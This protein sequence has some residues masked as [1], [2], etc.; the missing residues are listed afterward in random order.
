MQF[1]MNISLFCCLHEYSVSLDELAIKLKE[2]FHTE[3]YIGVLELVLQLYQEHLIVNSL[4][5]NKHTWC[6]CESPVYILNGSYPR[7]LMTSLGKLNMEWRRLECTCCKANIV[8][9][10]SALGI[11]KHQYKSNELEKLIVDAAAKDSY[12][13]AVQSI[14]SIGLVSVSSSTAWRWVIQ[15]DCDEIDSSG[16]INNADTPI[17]VFADG[18]KF[19]GLPESGK[20]AKGD[21]K[22]V[23]GV[24]SQGDVFPIGAWSGESWADVRCSIDQKI[25]CFPNDSILVAD[26][27]LGITRAFEDIIDEQQRCH[28]HINRD[29]YHA[30]WQN[31]GTVK[32]SKPVQ[33]ALRALLAIE[34]P[35]GDF[36]K[37]SEQEKDDIEEQMELTESMMSKLI[38]HLESK[39]FTVAAN[40]LFNAKRSMFGYIRRWLKLG[41]ICP[42]AS[43]LI[44]RVMRVL[45]RRIKKIAYNWSDKGVGK[46]ARII[47]KKFMDKKQWDQFWHDKLRLDGSVVFAISNI[48]LAD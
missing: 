5:K 48:K 43:S 9:L 12:R 13:S 24:D 42:R 2:L 7:K 45:A 31:G 15:S 35:E 10:K 26:G 47:L 40:Y 32:D 4:G 30:M 36:Q 28:W 46:I 37:V 8:P 16:R 14:D 27:E 3:G 22:A 21:L 18:T 39:G 33:H 23:I 34:L 44:E 20:A 19:K 25:K 6:T 17:Q 11:K 29:I 38:L 1:K 41:I